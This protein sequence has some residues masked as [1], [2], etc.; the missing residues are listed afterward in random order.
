MQVCAGLS[1]FSYSA[2]LTPPKMSENSDPSNFLSEIT[3]ES[4]IVKLNSGIEYHGMYYS[5]ED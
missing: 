3:G 2:T 4:V 1:S 5:L